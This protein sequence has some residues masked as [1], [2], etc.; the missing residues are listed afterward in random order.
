MDLDYELFRRKLL[1]IEESTENSY[2]DDG[3]NA[4]SDALATN[5]TLSK[6]LIKTPE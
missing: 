2:A 3:D 4:C 5:S 6:T 1:K